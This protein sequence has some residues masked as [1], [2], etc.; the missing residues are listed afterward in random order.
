MQFELF[1]FVDDL[2]PAGTP[3][4][5]RDLFRLMFG[6]PTRGRVQVHPATDGQFPEGF[7]Q[8]SDDARYGP[9]N[10]AAGPDA[11]DHHAEELGRLHH[12][13]SCLPC[14]IHVAGEGTQLFEVSV[15]L[16]A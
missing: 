9:V 4:L 12:F 6:H 1:G 8:R 13:G 16:C 2:P 7:P 5:L 10:L 3:I 14:S 15:D 11:V